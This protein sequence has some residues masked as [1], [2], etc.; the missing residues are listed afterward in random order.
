M[1]KIKSD[2]STRAFFLLH[3]KREE[4]L[5]RGSFFKIKDSKIVLARIKNIEYLK[6]HFCS[7]YNFGHVLPRLGKFK[8]KLETYIFSLKTFIFTNCRVFIFYIVY[9]VVQ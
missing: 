9:C 2:C 3:C 5:F 4:K 8:T 6:P 7:L 1:R